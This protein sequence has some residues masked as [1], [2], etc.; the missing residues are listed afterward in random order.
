[1][2]TPSRLRQRVQYSTASDGT[3][4]AWADSGSGPVVVKAANW[5]T[6]LEY[7]WESPVWRHWIQ[8]FSQHCRFIRFDERGCGMSE[9]RSGGLSIEQWAADLETIIEAACPSEPV[10]LLGISQGAATCIAYATA[11]PERVARMI[12]YGGYA[13]GK[14]LQ[15]MPGVEREYRAVIEV[16]RIGWGS[17][18]PA[19]RQLFTS[20]FIPDGT[21]EQIQWFNELCRK[22]APGHIA[23]ELMESRAV[24][25]VTHLLGTVTTPTL[26]LH[27]R[28]DKAIP[29]D[30]GRLLAAGIPNAQFVELDS[31]NHILLE[32]E[33]AWDRFREEVLD[34]LGL[35][36]RAADDSVFASLSSRERAVLALMA[37]GLANMD[38]AERLS[39]SEK[40]VRNHTSNIFDKLGVWS[41]AQAIVFARD[42]GF[43]GQIR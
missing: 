31:R 25:D 7:E 22:T 3:R 5:L 34:F 8:F 30:E 9:W 16:A 42:H 28:D 1:M 11:H 27:A 37:E 43:S 39:I 41:R 2:S 19:F 6:H 26:V 13:R 32:H 12:L 40:T 36:E 35:G 24:I 38:I 17:D 29:F 4:L 20:R 10:T 23:A 33:P 14:F 15:G 18:N 21:H